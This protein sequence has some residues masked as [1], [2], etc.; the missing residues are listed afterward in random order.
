MKNSYP[1]SKSFLDFTSFIKYSILL[2][3]IAVFIVNTA[4]AQCGPGTAVQAPGAL[5]AADPSWATVTKD[6]I[7]SVPANTVT[8][9]STHTPFPAFSS[10][11]FPL[12]AGPTSRE[13]DF[14]TPT[15][16]AQWT[17]TNLYILVTVPD[18]SVNFDPVPNDTFF[19]NY[20]A[21][22]VY[23]SGNN[24]HAGPPYG[25]DDVQYGFSNNGVYRGTGGNTTSST[26]TTGV[27][28]TA[29]IT[30]GVGYTMFITIPL[31]SFVAPSTMNSQVSFDIAIDDNDHTPNIA[32][33]MA[34]DSAALVAGGETP[35]AAHAGVIGFESGGD[36]RDAQVAWNS[37]T[38]EAPY[39]T[40]SDLANLV[41]TAPP[42]PATAGVES[43]CGS[44]IITLAGNTPSLG[45]TAQW[46]VGGGMASLTQLTGGINNP[47]ATFHSAG[48]GTYI[49]TWSIF[50]NAC[51]AIPT[52]ANDTVS[53]TPLPL[54]LVTNPAAVC[55]PG[56]VDITAPAVTAG[57][58]G[59]TTLTYFTDPSTMIPLPIPTA[60]ATSGTYYIQS[61]STNNCITVTPVTV[62]INI[63][64]VITV[65]KSDP[66][67]CASST[68]SFT[69]NGLIP[70]TIYTI[71]FD[72]GGV[73]Q[74][75]Q[76]L[77][78]TAAGTVTV[79]GLPQGSYTNIIAV[80]PAGCVSNA[81]SATLTDP[82]AP[83]PIA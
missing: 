68:G 62:T 51:S 67:A 35:A 52:T 9:N 66:T 47:L 33:K 25:N 31:S 6:T 18:L 37:T 1:R 57:S 56:T 80:P 3:S 11:G 21:V 82:A 12:L 38:G 29:T 75:P 32:T 70:G 76:T 34:I 65:T 61:T 55:S 41:L 4:I 5:T 16:Q 48:L 54:L 14:G 40:T 27:T 49:F 74:T 13:A 60:V 77:T 8:N 64:P 26:T 50:N 15:W 23:L 72:A 79:T 10:D 2:F 44:G 71:N 30:P 69:V 28:G 19:Y 22:E 83:T 59:G 24:A 20:D 78:A 45:E 53:V 7:G 58:S 81:G 36:Y 17:T 39:N 42:T 43:I 63:S 46:S 73:A